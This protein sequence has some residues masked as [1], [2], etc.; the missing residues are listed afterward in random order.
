[1]ATL[2]G[3]QL[4]AGPAPGQDKVPVKLKELAEG[5]ATRV[6][7]K[8]VSIFKVK[9]V[10]EKEKDSGKFEEVKVEKHLLYTEHVLERPDMGKPPTRL[11]RVYDKAEMRGAKGP[12]GKEQPQLPYHNQTLL[13]E[14]NGQRYEFR[15]EF[16]PAVMD[17]PNLEAEFNGVDLETQKRLFLPPGPVAAGKTWSIDAKQL[18]HGFDKTAQVTVGKAEGSGKLVKVYDSDGRK[19]G[20]VECTIELAFKDTSRDDKAKGELTT[21]QSLKLKITFDGCI[22][23]TFADGR[24]T[25]TSEY[26]GTTVF[27]GADQ[28]AVTTTSIGSSTTANTWKELSKK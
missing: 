24:V 2:F 12:D 21:D 18:L 19:Y 27:R 23:G 1:L 15:I 26:S 7:V 5:Q 8:D 14:K 3:L 4:L 16:G 10:L 20:V 9:S 22:D 13:I 28:P 25:M 11:K 6:E 17:E